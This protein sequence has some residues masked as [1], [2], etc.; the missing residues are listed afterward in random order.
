[1]RDIWCVLISHVWCPSTPRLIYYFQSFHSYTLADIAPSLRFDAHGYWA[2][3]DVLLILSVIEPSNP[4]TSS[5]GRRGCFCSLPR[6]LF[7]PRVWVRRLSK[8]SQTSSVSKAKKSYVESKGLLLLLMRRFE[9]FLHMRRRADEL[10][11]FCVLLYSI[12]DVR[13]SDRAS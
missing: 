8:R 4:T 3:F 9:T 10:L 5:I 2:A 13:V 1:M 12:G 7:A 6:P 11:S